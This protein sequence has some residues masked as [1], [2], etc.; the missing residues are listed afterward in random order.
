MKLGREIDV[1][2]NHLRRQG[3]VLDILLKDRTTG[4][5]IIW[6]TNSYNKTSKKSDPFADKKQM[7]ADLVTGDYGFLVQPRAAKSLEEQK[8]RTKDKAEV[9]TPLSVVEQMNEEIDKAS[10]NY[11]VTKSNWEA[12][13][14]ER[15]LEITCGEGPFIASRYDPVAALGVKITLK[16]RVGFLDKKLR[17][18]GKY[19]KTKEEWFFWV[20]EALKA[21]Y[22]YEWQGDNILIARENLL[23]TVID[24][25]HKKFTIKEL[26]PLEWREQFAEI[27]SWNV[28]QMDGLRYVIPM[29]CKKSIVE[30]EVED[31]DKKQNVLF[32]IEKPKKTFVECEGC[33]TKNPFRHTGRYAKIMDWKTGK[34]VRF[35]DLLKGS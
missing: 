24:F 20:V 25:Y 8:K 13:V 14:T 11:P 16:K 1:L 5:N 15:R 2:E 19:T 32:S 10:L 35:V 9:F 17:V 3:V 31:F 27:I 21:S 29:S 30:E 26:P 6:A 33:R 7:T 12:Y 18:I 22:G 34:K 4:R 23:Y 28:W